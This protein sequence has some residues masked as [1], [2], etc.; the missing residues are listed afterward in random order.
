MIV[1]TSSPKNFYPFNGGRSVADEGH[2]TDGWGLN[3]FRSRIMWLNEQP[4]P[5]RS[6]KSDKD[7]TATEKAIDKV[8]AAADTKEVQL[9]Y[10]TVSLFFFSVP[11]KPILI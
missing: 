1:N 7:K 5:H 11:Q 9:S 3:L 2:P 10:L 6:K 8:E 4:G